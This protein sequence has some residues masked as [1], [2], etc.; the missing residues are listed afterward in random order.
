MNLTVFD[1]GLAQWLHSDSLLMTG[2]MK[3]AGSTPAKEPRFTRE[4][5]VQKWPTKKNASCDK[6]INR[7]G[8]VL[9]GGGC[10]QV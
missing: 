10:P 8:N 2:K 7:E 4:K 1:C 6:W 9:A 3:V 5:S